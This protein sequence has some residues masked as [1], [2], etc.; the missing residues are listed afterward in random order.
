MKKRLIFT[1]ESP[2]TFKFGDTDSRLS[3]QLVDTTDDVNA[4]V[5]PSSFQSVKMVIRSK[6]YYLRDLT[7]VIDKDSVTVNSSD[8]ADL[9]A[10]SYFFEAWATTKDGKAEVYPDY[11]FLGFE[12]TQNGYYQAGRELAGVAVDHLRDEFHKY[13]DDRLAAQKPVDLSDYVKSEQL[14]DYAKKQDVPVV[15]YDSDKNTLSINGQRWELQQKIDLSSYAKKSDIPVVGLDVKD[16]TLSING[17]KVDIPAKVNLAQYVTSEQ[18]NQAVQAFPVITYDSSKNDL[19]VNGQKVPLVSDQDVDNKLTD[20][21][22]KTDLPVLTLDTTKRT[23]NLNGVSINIPA[24][25]DLSGYA[26]TSEVPKV[27][28]DATSKKLTVDGVD[29]PLTGG[30]SV[31]LSEYVKESDLFYGF[32]NPKFPSYTIYGS[33]NSRYISLGDESYLNNALQDTQLAF[34]R[35]WYP[36]QYYFNY[37]RS[38]ATIDEVKKRAMIVLKYADHQLN[39]DLYF[40][41]GGGYQKYDYDSSYKFSYVDLHPT[42]IP[43][44]KKLVDP[45]YSEYST[46]IDQASQIK[47]V[48]SLTMEC[49]SEI[50]SAI[51]GKFRVISRDNDFPVD[52]QLW[53]WC[54]DNPLNDRN[55][56]SYISN[57]WTTWPVPDNYTPDKEAK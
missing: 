39:P 24:S 36:S 23:L 18:F 43:K 17:V 28:Y 40:S 48:V 10:G 34:S 50:S 22:K 6:D 11:G 5:D 49:I 55:E 32:G 12:I 51:F 25:V 8:L 52:A 30:Q 41:F 14:W 47:T 35:L 27:T 56:Y 46:K 33:G 26:K 53:Y 4:P 29:V 9:P 15:A 20:Y 2:D 44:Y 31:D 54:F 16:R 42:D 37:K 38:F 7:P 57:D 3:M 13:V 45:I 21:A 1:K 19:E